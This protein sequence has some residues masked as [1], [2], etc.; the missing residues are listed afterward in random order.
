[1]PSLNTPVVVGR[2]RSAWGVR[3]DV[4]VETLS[5][6]PRRFAP[7]GVLQLRGK[8]VRV[9]RSRQGRRG[10][11]V[12]LDVVSDRTEAEALRGEELTVL[13]EQDD[14]LIQSLKTVTAR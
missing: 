4:S 1:M 5:D 10:M 9:E 3:G 6:A 14:D 13:P 12:K 11:L 2:I 8:P 7:G